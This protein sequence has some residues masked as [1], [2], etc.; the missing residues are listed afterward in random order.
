[1]PLA[2][3]CLLLAYIEGVSAARTFAAKHSYDLDPRQEFLVQGNP[4]GHVKQ[5]FG[6]HGWLEL[7][8]DCHHTGK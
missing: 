4:S 5:R 6:V 1:M 3:G 8:R 2:A 7:A